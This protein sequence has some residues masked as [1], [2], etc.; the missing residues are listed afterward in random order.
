[1]ATGSMDTTAKLWDVQKGA[2]ISTLSVSVKDTT[3]FS[4]LTCTLS[5]VLLLGLCTRLFA[6]DMTDI[7]VYLSNE[8]VA[9]FLN[10]INSQGTEFHFHRIISFCLGKS[11]WRLVTSVN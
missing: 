11:I 3:L 1:M 10:V 5:E 8:M 7:L 4:V 9:I 2:E 6:C